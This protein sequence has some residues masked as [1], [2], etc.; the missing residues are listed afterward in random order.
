[1]ETWSDLP[2][3]EKFRVKF[4]LDT[5][6]LAY[7]VDN[8]YSGLSTMMEYLKN[9]AFCDLISSKYVIFEFVGI[10]KREHYLREIIAN[11]TSAATGQLNVSSLLKYRD[12]FNAPEV[13]FDTVK[14]NI[15]RK[16]MQEL[17]DILNFEI[18]YEKNILHNDLL[19]PTFEL[20]LRTKISRHDSIVYIS[21]TWPDIETKEDFVFLISND[22]AFVQNTSHPD[23]DEVIQ[24][25]GLTK[26]HVEWMRSL[27][28]NNAHKINLTTSADDALLPIFLPTKLKELII[29]KNRAFFIG[30]TIQCGSGAGFPTDVVCF[31]LNSN[32]QLNNNIYLTIIG[33]DLDF[34]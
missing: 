20:T 32:T 34:I 6:I 23:V 9:S 2:V 14:S 4:Y 31:S 12:D 29:E 21:S 5:N 1:M 19:I 24:T 26:P 10:R 13:T 18:D 3:R 11:S 25:H 16:V 22:Q 15:E 17:K 8:T 33:K 30:K 28:E 7:I 27:Q